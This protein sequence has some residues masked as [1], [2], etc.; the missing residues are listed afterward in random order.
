MRQIQLLAVEDNY[1]DVY[2]LKLVLEQI[3]CVYALSVVTDGEA[4]VDFLLKRG[5]YGD[6]P[7]PDLILL[8]LN[9]PKL[10]G[11]EVLRAVPHARDLPICVMTSSIVE[12]EL[13]RQEFGIEGACYLIK[14]LD[15]AKLIGAL[16]CFRHLKPVAQELSRL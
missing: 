8:D 15:A 13:L 5:R 6:A 9:L 4:A 14:P 12:R 10:T 3:G 16:K 7:T 1:A 11:I 2:W